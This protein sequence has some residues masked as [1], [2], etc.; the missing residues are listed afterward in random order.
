MSL[1]TIITLLMEQ[2]A[3]FAYVYPERHFKLSLYIRNNVEPR[4]PYQFL[5]CTG[6]YCR[7]VFK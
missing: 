1:L 5:R 2:K 3:V 7:S 4:P 6:L